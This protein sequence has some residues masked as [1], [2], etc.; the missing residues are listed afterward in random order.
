MSDFDD[1]RAGRYGHLEPR[2][3]TLADGRTV[4]CLPRRFLPQ[5]RALA[6]LVEATVE[7][8]DRTDTL[9]ART[10]G[11]PL[12]FWRLCDA[13]DVMTPADLLTVGRRVRVPVPDF[14]GER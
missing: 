2:V 11:D 13:N 7:E 10:L 14:E 5:G 8:G 1:P 6:L 12:A 9:A 4:R 3:V